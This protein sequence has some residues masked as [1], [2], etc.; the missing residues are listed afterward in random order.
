MC[1]RPQKPRARR[2]ARRRGVQRRRPGGDPFPGEGG[3]LLLTM[4]KLTQIQTELKSIGAA[5]FQQL[6]DALLDRKGFGI[7]NPIG[8]IIGANKVDTGT[9]DTLIALPDGSY[10]FAE[11]TTQQDR[12][13]KKFKD[14]LDKC[15]DESKQASLSAEFQ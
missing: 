14:D 6:C 13:Y 10:V 2:T 4:S 15:F 7:L 5:E 8:T 11:Y 1:R 3:S 12:L 9:P